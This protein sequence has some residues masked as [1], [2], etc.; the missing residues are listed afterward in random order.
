SFLPTNY[1]GVAELGLVAGMGMVVAFVIAIT[2]LPALLMLLR[3]AGE[4]DDVGFAALAPLDAYMTRNRRTVLRIAAGAGL[5][6]LLL[7]AFLHFDSNP[8]DLRSPKVE[9]VSTLFDLM[10]NPQTSPNTINATASSLG[11][12]DQLAKNL[13]ALPQVAQA[14]TLSSF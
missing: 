9:S 3:P 5:I 7:T 14:L 8:L 4:A 13:S 2:L 11:E 6:A 1:L 10:G 12:A